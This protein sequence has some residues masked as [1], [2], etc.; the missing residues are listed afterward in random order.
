MQA[1]KSFIRLEVRRGFN[2][3]HI[4]FP[5]ERTDWNRLCW[6]IVEIVA[7]VKVTWIE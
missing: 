7:P 2:I 6:W 3:Q 5:E 1:S 4:E